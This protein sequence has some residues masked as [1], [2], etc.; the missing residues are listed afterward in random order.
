MAKGTTRH[1]KFVWIEY[2]DPRDGEAFTEGLQRMGWRN[3]LASLP[4]KKDGWGQRRV[5]SAHPLLPIRL[6]GRALLAL[7]NEKRATGNAYIPDPIFIDYRQA[8]GDLKFDEEIEKQN[9]F[10]CTWLFWL[11]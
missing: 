8:N 5:D 9:E 2:L 1:L 10:I 3:L 11:S 4:V 7:P 6:R